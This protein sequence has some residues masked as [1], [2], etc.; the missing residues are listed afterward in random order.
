MQHAALLSQGDHAYARRLAGTNHVKLPHA[1]IVAALCALSPAAGAAPSPS[2]VP[3]RYA[4]S[5][6]PTSGRTFSGVETI[7]AHVDGPTGVI[8]LD[9]VGLRIA[10][11]R[12]TAGDET[13]MAKV[14]D[15]AAGETIALTLPHAIAG[16]IAVELRWSG[17]TAEDLGGLF[18]V[19]IGA[20][21]ALF[22]HLEP[23]GARRVFPCVDDPR[24]KARFDLSVDISADDEAIANAPVAERT[25]LSGHRQRVRFAETAP[26]PTYLFAVAIGPFTAVERTVGSTAVRVVVARDQVA[27]ARFALDTAAELLPAFA[28]Y[29][30]RPYPFAKLDLVAV[31]SFAP[32]GMENAGAIFLRDDRVLVDPARA[33]PSTI[34]AVTML[35]AHELAHQWLGDLVTPV[36]WNDLWLSEAT[37]TYVAHETVA[38]AHPDWRPWDELQPA[39]DAVM[40]DD[41]LAATHPVRATDAGHAVFDSIVYTKG[42]ALLRML[43]QWIGHAAVRDGLRA[44]VADHEFGSI[45]ADDFW[46][47][48]DG[49]RATPVSDVAR[50]WFEERGHAIIAVDGSCGDGAMSVTLRR[51]GSPAMTVPVTLRWPDGQRVV[52]LRGD[53]VVDLDECPAWLEANGDRSGFYR[54]KYAPRLRASLAAA[55]RALTPAERVALLSDAW[56]D[57]RDGGPLSDYLSLATRLGGEQSPAVLDELGRRL[58]FALGQ[59]VSPADQSAFERLVFDL[60]APSY[61]ALGWQPRAGEDDA[62]RLARGRVLDLLGT[63]AHDGAIRRDA[64]RRIRQYLANPASLDPALADAVVTLGAQMGDGARYGA[65]VARAKLARTPEEQ[66]R[67]RDALAQFQR[68]QLLQRTLSLLLTALVPPDALTRFAADLAD[69]TRARPAAWRFLKSH[70]DVLE[71]KAP[72][73]GWLLPAT[74]RFC[75]ETSAREVGQFLSAREPYASLARAF[76]ETTERIGRCA[77][78]R[79][80]TSHELADWLRGHYA[81]SRAPAAHEIRSPR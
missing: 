31:P 8:T 61:A 14:G 64:E 60:L 50:A 23:S 41:E 51:V 11:A 53:T 36:A 56:L 66:E 67:F 65:Y 58:A 26:L 20:R 47:A 30:D 55:A 57:V 69:N 3:T 12:V 73:T 76:A 21:R 40:A 33:S 38:R 62:T 34:H 44:L 70:F 78:L 16:D 54:V 25:P 71:R 7:D 15:G 49:A 81:L 35:I 39:I 59:L 9:S 27:L 75:D 22:T 46:S 45:A 80:R 63:V 5:L 77:K 2:L 19:P 74:E 68:P 4:I 18:A 29:F 1:L 72:R 52:E 42:A 17:T 28:A 10:E 24:A 32:G 13:L 43:G 79:D 48:I 37:A 6:A